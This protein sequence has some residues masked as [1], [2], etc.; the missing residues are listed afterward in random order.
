MSKR[1]NVA[2]IGAGPY[3][4]SLAAHLRAAGVEYRIFGRPMDAWRSHMPEGM[5]LKSDG[6]ASNLY[7]PGGDYP[8]SRFCREQGIAYDDERVPVRLKTF[9]DYG[10]AFK[11]RF[12]PGLEEKLVASLTREG[13]GF[14]LGLDD[15][16]TIRAR[17]VVAA[18][19]IGGFRFT[20]EALAELPA[21]YLSHSYDHHD[22]ALLAGRRVAVIGGGASAIDLAGLL[23]ERGCEVRLVCRRDALKFGSPPGT[24]ERSP[25]QRLRHPR[26]G[27]GPGLR[28]RLCT[29]APLLFH[30][31]PEALR[32]EVVRRHLGPAASWHMKQ[33]VVARVPVL[34]G[35]DVVGAIAEDDHV[36]LSLQS[37]DNRRVVISADHVITATG[38]RVGI[39]RLE[40]LDAALI[41]QIVCV[42][43]API[44]STRFESSVKGLF[45]IGPTAAN[46]FGP[47]MRFAYG[48]RFASRRL[49]RILGRRPYDA[50]GS[51]GNYEASEPEAHA[52]RMP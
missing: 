22:L 14:E 51:P 11:D 36:E 44:L 7:D 43:E 41:S 25:W 5:L 50:S 49:V 46:S 37:P 4:L 47:L 45:F 20:P 48:A 10:L 8:L 18:V 30:F 31:M 13:D 16:S 26:S 32:L 23:N 9:V 39:R 15:G 3:G 2:I 40:F 52:T 38:Y 33:K 35:H 29:D 21:K 34:S 17:R 27:L 12:V 42:N 6:F 24:R 19:G 28:S 1:T